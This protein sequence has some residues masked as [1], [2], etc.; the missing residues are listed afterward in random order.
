MTFL[1]TIQAR[2]LTTFATLTVVAIALTLL[3]IQ[4]FVAP[5]LEE[6]EIRLVEEKVDEIAQ[7][8][9]LN[10]ARIESQSRAIT[11]TTALLQSEQIDAVLP[12]LIDQYGDQKVFGGGIWPLPNMRTPGQ[13]KH[14]TFYHRDAQGRLVLNTHWNSAESLNY[15]EQPWYRAGLQAPSGH[16]AWAAAYKD[17]ASAEPRTNCAMAIRKD[18]KAYGVSTID[19]TLGFFNELVADKEKEIQGQ[20]MI[21]EADGKILSNLPALNEQIVLKNVSEL[22]ARTPFIAQIGSALDRGEHRVFSEFEAAD[23][24]PTAFF[25]KPIEG[26]PWL[27]ATA[28]PSRLLTEKTSAMLGTLGWLQLPIVALLLLLMV[29]ALRT[30]MRR[31][32]LLTA[33]IQ[34]LSSG[35]ADLTRRIGIKGDDEVDHIGVAVNDFIVY[36]QEM[37]ADLAASSRQISAELDQLKRQSSHTNAIL[38]R[39]ASETDQA[40]TAITEM[41]S[42]ADSVAQSA[43]ETA[44]FTQAA[45]EHAAQSRRTVEEAANSVLDLINEVE[46]ATAQVQAM[47]QDARRINDVLGV[48]GEIAG[49]TNLLALNAAIEAARAGEQ[50]RGFAVVADEVRAL[51]ART[52]QSTSQIDEML[53]AL[54]NAVDAAVAAMEKTRDSCQATADKTTRVNSGLDQMADSTNRI[55]DLSA[56]IAA[57][58]EEQSAVSG[59]INQNMVAVRDMVDE[60]VESGVTV[61]RSTDALSASNDRLIGMVNRF[62]L[63]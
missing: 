52:Q 25:L 48:I 59:E 13:A 47:Q 49:Q 7:A 21:V 54:Q 38:A 45:N 15:F 3:G 42:T 17:D 61:G 55:H 39:H 6:T 56:Q 40:V 10:L 36:L 2:Y 63:Q 41:S 22:A 16:C 8:I 5:Q 20:I 43:N 30:L 34:S 31:L 51:A 27:L 62:K 1:K 46:T 50:G 14:S 19:L 12:G 60:L 57:A 37:I 32:Q 44:S 28:L 58:A 33:N 26:T 23:G 9:Q 4:K 53:A 18:G 11:Q 29:V 24:E 35:D